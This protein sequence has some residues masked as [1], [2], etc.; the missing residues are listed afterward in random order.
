MKRPRAGRHLLPRILHHQ[1]FHCPAHALGSQHFRSFNMTDITPAPIPVAE[2]DIASWAKREAQRAELASQILPQNKE[3][4]FDALA[5][6][7]VATVIVT[8]DGCGDS[9]QIE[10]ITA[11]AADD[12]EM[13]LPD[14]K[15]EIAL[16]RW[17]A[18]EP[19][20]VAT[21]LR[22]AIEQLCYEF[23]GQTHGGWENNDGAYGEFS[24]DVGNRTIALEHNQRFASSELYTH[25]W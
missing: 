23:L 19:Q 20:P 11:R 2:F 13:E 24:F 7:G 6:A 25:E 3:A 9:G 15:I 22:D 8:F 1:S 18:D 16:L 17:H 10:D 21:G 14:E 4:L 5:L 12:C